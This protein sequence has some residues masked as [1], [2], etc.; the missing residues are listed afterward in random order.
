MF[1]HCAYRRASP[2]RGDNRRQRRTTSRV[3]G[4]FTHPGKA[5]R[6]PFGNWDRIPDPGLCAGSD[7]YNSNAGDSDDSTRGDGYHPDASDGYHS[8]G[9]CDSA[10]GYSSAVGCRSSAAS[11][12]AHARTGDASPDASA[13][14]G[15]RSSRFIHDVWSSDCACSARGR[16][17]LCASDQ[18]NQCEGSGRVWS[19]RHRYRVTE[20]GPADSTAS[21]RCFG[22]R[23]QSRFDRTA[24]RTSCHHCLG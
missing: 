9:S 22:W 1:N 11:S 13:P 7:R 23:N 12:R 8:I 10:A 20:P 4:G 16:W 15:E 14:A 5:Q 19:H 3:L 2:S 17:N 18:Q 24:R 6:P 21:D